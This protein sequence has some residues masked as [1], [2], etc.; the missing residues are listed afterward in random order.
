MKKEKIAVLFEKRD[1]YGKRIGKVINLG[2]ASSNKEA[3]KMYLH[4]KLHGKKLKR[5][6]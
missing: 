3:D 1:I 2:T 4:Y 5:K 6:K